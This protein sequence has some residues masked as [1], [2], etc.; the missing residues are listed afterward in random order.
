MNLQNEVKNYWEAHPLLD[1]EIRNES[2]SL[3]WAKLD[4]VKRTDVEKFA[5]TYWRFDK[6]KELNV[7]DIGCGPGWLTVKY[8]EIKQ[9]CL[10]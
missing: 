5:Q 7:L 1:F 2:D 6:V 4:E 3:R 8:A 9:M 10:P